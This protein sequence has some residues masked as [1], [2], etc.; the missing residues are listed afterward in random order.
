MPSVY[1]AAS[2]LDAQLVVDLLEDAGLA[3]RLSAPGPAGQVEVLVGDA[4]ADAARALV[5]HLESG[6]AE[7]EDADDDGDG[8]SFESMSLAD[9][10]EDLLL[11][12][13]ALGD[14]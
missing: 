5:R 8:L 2:A 3:A 10:D 14:D 12:S 11:D 1:T 7:L 4:D 13:T 9:D 6:T